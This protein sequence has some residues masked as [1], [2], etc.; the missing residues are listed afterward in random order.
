MSFLISTQVLAEEAPV[1]DDF[2]EFLG[3]MVELDDGYISPL[4][5]YE[6]GE[7]TGE[8]SE[9]LPLSAEFE[10]IKTEVKE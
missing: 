5:L 6:F 3:S 10:A 4:D 9:E 7:I 1:S 8:M 2:L